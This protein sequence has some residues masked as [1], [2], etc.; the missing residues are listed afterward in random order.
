MES[1]GSLI[2]AVIGLALCSLPGVVI[3]FLT[4]FN[5]E[6]LAAKIASVLALTALAYLGSLHF[7]GRKFER[8]WQKISYRLS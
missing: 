2:T 4:R 8:D 1:G 7:A 3:I 5:S 6:L